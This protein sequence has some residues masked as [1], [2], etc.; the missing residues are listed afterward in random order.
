MAKM[1]MISSEALSIQLSKLESGVGEIAKKA[2][3]VGAKV[4]AD[5]VKANLQ[6]LPTDKFRFLRDGDKL[7]VL[8]ELQKQDLKDGFGVTPIK[9]DWDGNYNAK[10]GFDGYGSKPTKA[11]PKGLP[12]ILL[13]RAIESGSSVRR[14]KPFFRPAVS[15]SEERA[16]K[17]M[18]RV[19]N[20]E[21]E[22][23]TGGK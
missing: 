23:I 21:I 12:N 14:K 17:E 1:T 15:A 8:T 5:K 6:A 2:I 20:E 18:E 3:Y 11:Y 19:A 4:V 7:N 13:A 10:I 22:K 9:Q 16:I